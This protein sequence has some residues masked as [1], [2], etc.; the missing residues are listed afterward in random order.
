MR[1]VS[2]WK[3]CKMRLKADIWWFRSFLILMVTCKSKSI[4]KTVISQKS[5]KIAAKNWMFMNNI[6]KR[7]QIQLNLNLFYLS[8]IQKIYTYMLQINQITHWWNPNVH[9]LT[10]FSHFQQFCKQKSHTFLR[11]ISVDKNI[12]L[13]DKLLGIIL[14]LFYKKMV[15]LCIKLFNWKVR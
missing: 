14:E 13:R 10:L 3:E 8:T 2:K 7:F 5:M 12:V 11:L 4:N 1:L 6:M 15:I 9:M